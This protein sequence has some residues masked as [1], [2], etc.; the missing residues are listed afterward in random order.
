MEKPAQTATP[1]GGEQRPAAPV[2]SLPKGGGAVRGIGEK[3]A[4]NPVT[5]TG[6]FKV[7]IHASPGRSDFGPELALSYD[8]G[9]GNGL[10]GLG[11]SLS[12]PSITRK[13]DKG[14]PRYRDE[15][16]SD[17][18]I[19]SGS[20]DL[21][22]AP[23]PP[24]VGGDGAPH[25]RTVGGATYRVRLYRPR[26][27]GLFARIE[28]WTNVDTGASHWRSITKDNVTTLFGKDGDSRISEPAEP[29]PQRPRR[30]SAWLISESYDD[31]GNAIVYEYK[32]E[33]A[34]GVD[35]SRANEKNRT[36]PARSVN[37][38][39]KRIKYGNRVSR[40]LEPALSD[41]GWMF[42]V[43]FD[44]GE[45]DPDAPTPND[46]GAWLCRNDPFSSNRA[47]FEVRTYRLCQRVLMFHHFPAEPEVGRDCLVRSTDFA[48]RST[49]DNPDDLKRGDPV[50]SCIGSVTQRGYKRAGAGYATR[51]MPPL[52]FEYSRPTI[53]EEVREVEGES[54]E[55]LP[56]GLDGSRYQWVDLDGEGL[57]GV[58][59]EQAGGWFYKRNLSAAGVRLEEGA[60]TF[61]ARFAPAEVVGARPSLAGLSA[62]RLQFLDLAGDGQ[63]DL[64]RF[65]PPLSGFYERTQDGDWSEFTTFSS[66]PNVAWDDPNLRFVDLSGDGHADILISE[67]SVFTWYPSLAE[68]GF[69]P[70][71]RASQPSDEEKGPRL[72]FA[73]GTQSIHLADMSGDGLT[74]IVRVRNGEVCY[75]PN[76]GYGLF[77]AKVTMDDAPWFD[78]PDQF[79]QKRIRLADIDGS[80]V[81]DIIYL[82]A[83]G[84]RIYFNQSGNAWGGAQTLAHFPQIND[85]SSVQVLDLLGTGTA[86]LVWSSALPG[87]ARRP[88]RYVDLMGQKP[89]LL[90]RAVN[91]LGAETVVQYAPSTKFYLQDRRDGAPWITRLPFPVHCVER[92]ESYDR[93]SGNRFVSR[94]KYHHGY[95]DGVE[96]EFRGFGMVEQWDTEEIGSV[97]AGEGTA[98]ATNLDAASFVPPIHTKT[99]FHTGVHLGRERGAS[100]FAGLTDAHDA[101][102]FYR[103]P[104]WDD[105]AAKAFL[106]DDTL[107]PDGLTHDEEREACRALKGAMLRQEVY[108]LDGTDSAAHPYSV[109]EQ[110]YTVER[111]QPRGTSPHAVF[112]THAREALEYHYER[113]PH[114]PRVGHA[115]T[116]EVDEYGNVVKSVAIGYGRRQSPLAAQEDRDKQARTLIIYTENLFTNPVNGADR[117]DDYR[118]PLPAEMRKFELTGYDLADA[119]PRL[120]FSDFVTPDTADP[121][122]RKQNPVFDGQVD[123]EEPATAG[124]RRRLIEHVRTVYR[125]DDLSGLLPPGQLET[126]A[127]P[128][129]VYKLA[130][131]PGLLARVYKRKLGDAP[132]ENLLPDAAAVLG[133]K[134]GDQG[135]YVDAD[136]DGRWWIPSERLFYSTTADVGAPATTAAA[137]L[138]EARQHFFNYRKFT[139]AFDRDT[140]ADYDAH[141]LLVVGTQD[142]AKNTTK[143]LHDYRVLQPARV[144]D[145]NGNRSEARFDALGMVVG[146]ALRGKEGAAAEGDSFDA[147]DADLTAEQ[148]KEYFDAPDPGPLALA[149]LGTATTRIIYDLDRVPACAAAVARETHASDLP[150]GAQTK[151]QLS[152]VYSDGYGRT[153]QTKIQAEPGRLNPSDLASP[154]LASRWVGSGTKVYNNKGLPVRQYE[155][156]FSQSPQFGVEQHGVSSTL[157]YDPAE[158]VVAT[159]HPDHTWEKA[160]FDPWRRATYDVN[161][162]LMRADGSTDP[163][164]D[165]DVKGFFSRLPEADYRPTW[166]EQRIS[167]AA[168]DPERIAAEKGAVHR[169]TPTIACLDTLGRT[170]LT[171]THN[172]FELNGSIVEEEYPARVELDIEGNQREVRDAVTQGGDASGRV[173]ARYEYDMLGNRVRQTSMEAGGRWMLNDVTGKPLRAWDGRGFGRRLSYDEL[174]R[175]VGLFVAEDGVERL[176]ER[177]VYGEGQGAAEN[178][179]TRVFKVFDGAG[180]VTSEAYDFKGNLLSSRRDLSPDYKNDLDWRLN[181]ATD[182]G[183]FT[184]RTTFD[185]LNRPVAVT[186]PDGSSYRPSYNEAN[187]L[188]KVE[189]NLRG[190]E[191]DGAPVWTPFVT[192]VEYTAKGQRARIRYAN[193]AATAYEYDERTFRLARLTTTRAP[194]QQT[195]PASQL[196]KSAA[197]LQDLRYAYDP[198][199]NITRVDD[200]APRVVVHDN[201]QA[202]P[203]CDYTYDAVYRLVRAEGREHVGQTAHAFQPAGGDFRDYPFAGAGASP[204]DLQALRNYAE[205]YEYD[206]VGNFER[207]IHEAG[208]SGSWTRAYAYDEPS[209]TEP[210]TKKSNRLSS[211]TVGQTAESYAYDAHGS[212]TAM[213]HLTLMRWNAQ[214]ELRA[215]SA[216]AVNAGTPETTFYV[217]DMA[218]RRA[219]K[220]TERQNGSRRSERLYLGG[221]EL[222]REY[223]G[224]GASVTVERET[225]HVMD[226]AQPVALVETKTVE[227]GARLDAPPPV[228]RYQLGNHLGSS[229]LELDGGGRLISYEEYHPYGTTAFAAAAAAEV[230]RKR[231]RYTGKERDEETGLY[232]HGERYYAPW[233]GRWMAADP[234]GLEAGLNLYAYV[235]NNPV[236]LIDPSGTQDT[237]PGAKKEPGWL[238]KVGAVA[239]VAFILATKQTPRQFGEGMVSKGRSITVDPIIALADSVTTIYGPGGM[240]NK[241]ADKIVDR[242]QGKP[243]KDYV[244]EEEHAKQLQ[245]IMHVGGALFPGLGEVKAV[246]PGPP[247]VAPQGALVSTATAVAIP[248]AVTKAPAVLMASQGTGGGGTKQ[249]PAPDRLVVGRGKATGK[250]SV[251]DP[252]GMTSKTLAPGSAKPDLPGFLEK[253]PQKYPHL[254]GKL[255]EVFVERLGIFDQA[256]GLGGLK[257][258]GISA[259]REML[260]PGGTLR[261]L[262]Q[263]GA[264]QTLQQLEAQIRGML[265]SAQWGEV[266]VT[267]QMS[268]KNLFEGLLVSAKKL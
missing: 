59:T 214:D 132:E 31:R 146:T 30:V 47:G 193:G 205:R 58:L 183:T 264:G 124:R 216:Q 104:G 243:P 265:P 97:T 29:E 259:A 88:M 251:P 92:V 17:V 99:W 190:M 48:Y 43:V 101:G 42:E 240:I 130:F 129:Q 239:E 50:V 252:P 236:R 163:K 186:A 21:V 16:D 80:G 131:T 149:H 253:A 4:A 38:H 127:L 199:G 182:D 119:A 27:E 3:F 230:S 136:A 90:V 112:F 171:V 142:A 35:L 66:I 89:H 220:V 227:G 108:G 241:A 226:D 245:A 2:I 114:D 46:A 94:Y 111:L 228:S 128:G 238:E 237:P 260:A 248:A 147:F 192:D 115:M 135:G 36:A 74:D 187:L 98:A 8:S 223:D 158:R 257:A 203:R 117:P 188:D 152:F 268:E 113:N 267:T 33:D 221:F 53:R 210:A 232:Y 151:V 83:D 82:A 249:E 49:R 93:V 178:H 96:R 65:A 134:G 37:L 87:D 261:I 100:Y 137:E 196:F 165:E 126:L 155:P 13:T 170:F 213:P 263:P 22:P 169:Q 116:L 235:K 191:A 78:A 45:H 40:L 14:L 61:P 69:G 153:A 123:Y 262:Q 60:E 172:R 242:I 222:Y 71:E 102:E 217:Y 39:P 75:W 145:P 95:F 106:L 179:R 198:A 110:N 256:G 180:V 224:S 91:H 34:A 44:Y 154:A 219:R 215:T 246:I 194:S 212:M 57:S 218:G 9:A 247:M 144:T 229:S 25:T 250:S 86:C 211:T 202:A 6:S 51:A 84:V 7:P 81:T 164:A 125:R 24:G 185:A 206:A 161:D 174:R 225:L 209:L 166:H 204:N 138:A 120:Q 70:S 118:A 167:L 139:D 79:D 184:T 175:P 11:W 133:G 10:F 5:G 189:V 233:L 140:T 73:D 207:V 122:G 18:F 62:G 141:Q 85:A 197:T 173:V 76:L 56:S 121:E 52:E 107:L 63:P 162:T 55:N 244:T 177:T 181:H 168:N 67:E 19:L 258:E 156:F 20:E 200:N 266:T 41:A 109:V 28:R 150:E 72:V 160:V 54:V 201:K 103:E 15:E 195:A 64:V 234:I 12:L 255:K 176:A 77:G 32:R 148:I 231:Y 254:V 23:P 105:A 159:L 157:F 208:P 26:V 1:G 143:A 68:K